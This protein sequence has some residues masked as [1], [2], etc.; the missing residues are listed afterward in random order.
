MKETTAGVQK[1]QGDRTGT[2]CPVCGDDVLRQEKFS[3]NGS[4]TGARLVCARRGCP[5]QA[6]AD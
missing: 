2:T 5:W 1:K 6:K 3:T 4:P